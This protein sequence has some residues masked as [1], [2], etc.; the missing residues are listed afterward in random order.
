MQK[1]TPNPRFRA[2]IAI[3]VALVLA[4]GSGTDDGTRL[5]ETAVTQAQAKKYDAA[6]ASLQQSLQAGFATPSQ[7]L[8][9]G[10]FRPMLHDP[11][12]RRQVRD[13]LAAHAREARVT[14]VDADE[15]GDP[16]RFA[17]TL[18]DAKTGKP[19]AGARIYFYQTDDGGLYAPE[20]AGSG[21]G[22]NNPRLFCYVRPD[23]DGHFEVRSVVP[24]SYPNSSV[25][26]HVHYQ[27][28]APSYRDLRAEFILDETPRPSA[29]SREYARNRGWPV[30]QRERAE[31][32]V[33]QVEI[34]LS[35]QPR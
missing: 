5:F 22:S 15:P 19:V 28:S 3:I 17:G 16:F 18:T 4:A 14:M 11:Q 35:L 26:R 29:S 34:E 13:L 25:S 20:F 6:L 2:L 12:M 32:G 9:H 21:G 30:V 1:P 33:W 27:I 10:A 23:A 31:D 24:G 7:V 8:S